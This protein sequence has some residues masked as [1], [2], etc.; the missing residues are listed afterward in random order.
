VLWADVGFMPVHTHEY[1]DTMI[2]LSTRASAL[3][4]LAISLC[5]SA[6]TA[7]LGFPAVRAGVWELHAERVLPNGKSQRWTRKAEYCRDPK[8]IFQGYWGLGS[9]ERAGCRFESTELTGNQYRVTSECM[10]RGVGRVESDARITVTDDTAFELEVDVREGP[11][12]YRATE[13]GQRIGDCYE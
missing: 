8:L 6:A 7:E 13:R 9:V 10:I 3:F 1:H 12:H 2:S 11:Q 5:A 4:L